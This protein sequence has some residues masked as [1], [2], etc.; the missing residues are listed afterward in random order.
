M[1]FLRLHRNRLI[2]IIRSVCF[3]LVLNM[4]LETP[5]LFKF[6]SIYEYSEAINT[7]LK[8]Y[9]AIVHTPP[10]SSL[11]INPRQYMLITGIIQTVGIVSLIRNPAIAGS[12]AVGM[13]AFSEFASIYNERF[14]VMPPNPMCSG[15]APVCLTTHVMH[16]VM[17]LVALTVLTSNVGFGGAFARARASII[18][19]RNDMVHAGEVVKDKAL[20]A[21]ETVK[22]KAYDVADK[23]ASSLIPLKEKAQDVASSVGGTLSGAMH[24]VAQKVG[25]ES[26]VTEDNSQLYRRDDLNLN[27]K[28]EN[29]NQN[30]NLSPYQLQ[31]KEQ[32]E[33]AQAASRYQQDWPSMTEEQRKEKFGDKYATGDIGEERLHAGASG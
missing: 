4:F 18:A 6:G 15:H 22:D 27:R 13:V 19:I 20:D 10:L 2:N 25:L 16:I 32:L 30:L 12:I 3:F 8:M 7:P 33:R 11:N 5:L 23:T 14:G 28:E 17:F 24:G 1:E 21:A 31:Q 29:V 26:S 9:S